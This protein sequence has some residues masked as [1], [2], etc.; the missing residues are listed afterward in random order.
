M[1]NPLS[2]GGARSP[3]EQIRKLAEKIIPIVGSLSHLQTSL[4]TLRDNLGRMAELSARANAALLLL[5]GLPRIF[6]S[7]LYHMVAYGASHSGAGPASLGQ[8]RRFSEETQAAAASVI[9]REKFG[10]GYALRGGE[11]KPPTYAEKKAAE[12]ALARIQT[13][14]DAAVRRVEEAV[15]VLARAMEEH[16]RTLKDAQAGK[17]ESATKGGP[18]DKTPTEDDAFHELEELR[19]NNRKQKKFGWR[20]NEELLS[21]RDRL[22][23]EEKSLVLDAQSYPDED[24]FDPRTRG[25]GKNSVPDPSL[26]YNKSVIRERLKEINEELAARKYK[27]PKL[28]KAFVNMTGIAPSMDLSEAGSLGRGV[29]GVPGGWNVLGS[30]PPGSLSK[31]Q[32]RHWAGEQAHKSG[33]VGQFVYG[34]MD[35]LG[36][37]AKSASVGLQK[38][39]QTLARET[40][41]PAARGLLLWAN[42]L[43]RGNGGLAKVGEFFQKLGQKAAMPTLYGGAAAGSLLSAASPDTFATLT[44]SVKLLAIALGRHLI[45]AAM[46]ASFQLQKWAFAIR[47]LDP[48][49]MNVLGTL[50]AFAVAGAGA[51]TVLGMFATMLNQIG[52]LFAA[53]GTRL[54]ALSGPIGLL[55]VAIGALLIKL[56]MDKW[57]ELE[58]EEKAKNVDKDAAE[59]KNIREDVLAELRDIDKGSNPT[60]KGRRLRDLSDRLYKDQNYLREVHQGVHNFYSEGSGRVGHAIMEGLNA[61]PFAGGALTQGLEW[62]NSKANRAP[63]PGSY[64]DVVRK[65]MAEGKGPNQ[66]ITELK[67]RLVETE[68]NRKYVMGLDPEKPLAGQKLKGETAEERELKTS[69]LLMALSSIKGTAQY[70]SIEEAHKRTQV[71]AAG[72]DPITQMI[73]QWQ[74]DNLQ[75]ALKS[76][77]LLESNN[78]LVKQL[79]NLIIQR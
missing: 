63:D 77:G 26:D 24:V 15:A 30:K 2:P 78:E 4:S 42:Q 38:Y 75:V 60:E 45:P 22:R 14:S 72:N 71:M 28:N 54:G 20:S 76:A 3:D 57:K 58:V 68:K 55:G 11:G 40:R 49:V 50:G 67:E 21:E 69:T 18:R 61:V 56:G 62:L 59:G 51:V 5:V 73:E 41:S 35:K 46:F 64:L 8:K 79:I 6:K 37:Y 44:G 23:F 34:S 7:D 27:D 25:L 10:G 29:K 9:A 65:G 52:T 48:V 33:L 66:I 43:L 12:Q 17:G 13:E 74:K 31:W 1:L 16:T 36:M 19:E 47:E 70:S 32:K 53:I 39:I